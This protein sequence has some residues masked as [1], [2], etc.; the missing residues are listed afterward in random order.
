MKKRIA[1]VGRGTAGSQA[2]IHYLKYMSNCEIQW[3]F[4]STILT[5]SVGEGSTLT[6]PKNLFGNLNFN[7]SN[8]DEIDATLKTGIYKSGWG[9]SGKNFLHSFIPPEVSI[10]FNAK[11]LQDF[12]F[13]RIKD[14]VS[15]FDETINVN[16]IDADYIMDCSGKPKDYNLFYESS[17]IPVNSAHI[18]QC[19]WEYPRFQ[20]TLTIARPYGWV[21]GIPLKNRCSIGYL[22][23]KNI[24]NIEDIK[25]DV[26]EIFNDY[27]LI[28]SENTNYLEFKNYYRKNNYEER[29]IHNG[30]SSFFLEPLEATSIELMNNI[31][32]SS[33]D[34]WNNNSSLDYL[35][36]TYHKNILQIETMIMLHYFSGSIY[37]TTFWK[38]AKKMGKKCIEKSLKCD[39]D[40]SRM[41]KY[42]IN[43]NQM[44]M[45]DN[46]LSYG[47]WWEGSFIQNI[48]G[49]GIKEDLLSILK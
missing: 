32:R 10:H 44:N 4:D 22:F 36:K 37:D 1:I 27:N 35:N 25:T 33:F 21:F 3:Y 41:I 38:F 2:I 24:N 30:N 9:K 46:N 19:Y 15:I 39:N 43:R 17:F 34:L 18:T 20:Y 14:K 13:E 45:C 49:L 7:Y 26:L 5:Q 8:F 6:L 40:F 42:S 47:T 29:I 31:Q 28:P 48:N 11:S 12:I 23:N 16:K